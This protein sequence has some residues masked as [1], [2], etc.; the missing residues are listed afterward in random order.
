MSLFVLR[1][2]KKNSTKIANLWDKIWN[3]EVRKLSNGPQHD[4][5]KGTD[6]LG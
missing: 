1:K 2:H 4:L 5:L 6:H 3:R